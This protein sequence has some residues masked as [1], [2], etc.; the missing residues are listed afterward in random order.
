MAFAFLYRYVVQF[1]MVD[2][3][4]MFTLIQ[5]FTGGRKNLKKE[6]A[7][8]CFLPSSKFPLT[9]ILIT[10]TNFKLPRIARNAFH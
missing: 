10:E 2:A 1:D 3:E 7:A 5:V 6:V 4:L 8:S 9:Y